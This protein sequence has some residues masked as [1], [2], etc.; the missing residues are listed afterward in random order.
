MHSSYLQAN[1]YYCILA[2]R[3]LSISHS[4][5]INNGTDNHSH[6][7]LLWGKM[8]CPTLKFDCGGYM[9]YLKIDALSQIVVP[10]NG[11]PVQRR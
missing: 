8:F 5:G 1:T 10:N 11:S 4:K 7:D 2:N 6:L 3:K 9:Y